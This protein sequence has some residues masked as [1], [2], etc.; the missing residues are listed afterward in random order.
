MKKTIKPVV[1]WLALNGADPET[2]AGLE[3]D[4]VI[5][6]SPW[7][8]EVLPKVTYHSVA[9]PDDALALHAGRVLLRPITLPM[10]V[11]PPAGL[12][13]SYRHAQTAWQRERDVREQMHALLARVRVLTVGPQDRLVISMPAAL[14]VDA[15]EACARVAQDYWG[16]RV[17]LL[18]GADLAVIEPDDEVADGYTRQRQALP[19]P[20]ITP[21]SAY[22]D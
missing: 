17:M 14:P 13:E 5:T 8:G 1:D 3:G 18:H 6:D 7:P 9:W 19:T 22:Q 11:P 20:K 4:I 2:I 21:P 12:L 10:H 16:D 15:F